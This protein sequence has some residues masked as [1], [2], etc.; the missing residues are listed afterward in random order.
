M[1]IT[2]PTNPVKIPEVPV[3]PELD[4]L[5]DDDSVKSVSSE[6][7]DYKHKTPKEPVVKNDD[8]IQMNLTTTDINL[9]NDNA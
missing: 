6:D 2:Q 9:K 5:L 1:A 3:K 8:H 4:L 7:E